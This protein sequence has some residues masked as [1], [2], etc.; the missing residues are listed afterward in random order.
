MTP[1]QNVSVHIASLQR[2]SRSGSLFGCVSRRSAVGGVAT[3]VLVV[4]AHSR[5]FVA[6]VALPGIAL[7]LSYL[8]TVSAAHAHRAQLRRLARVLDAAASGDLT[9]AMP[10]VSG[11]DALELAAP[12]SAVLEMLREAIVVMS[13]GSAALLTGTRELHGLSNTMSS[14]AETTAA[15]ATAVAVAADQVSG[16]AQR[17][18]AATEEF[19]ATIRDVAVHAGEASAV[20]HGATEQAK[21][22]NATVHDLGAASGKVTQVVELISTIARQTH[23]LAL[24]ATLEAARA[25]EAGRGFAVV[26]GEVKQLA[27]QTAAATGSVSDTVRSMQEGAAEV[28]GAIGDITVTIGRVSESQGAIAA[29]VEEQTAT[30]NEMGRSA[31]EAANGA[32]SIADNIAAL[33]GTARATA[34]AG[35]QSRTTAAEFANLAG[36]FT[37]ITERYRI[38]DRATRAESNVRNLVTEAVTNGSV[39]RIEDTV[40][41]EGLH[42]FSFR[43]EWR[44]STGNIESDGTNSYSCND[45]DVAVL[46]FRGTRASFFGVTDANHGIVGVSVDDGPEQF[47]DEYSASRAA[48]VK[49]WTSPV[50]S[51]GEHVLTIRVTGR[52]NPASR[53]TWAAVD[54]VDVS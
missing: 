20:A 12:A 49:L 43:G 35:A 9:V 32:A 39:T 11:K 27:E 30:T 53:Y 19:N 28:A 16:S 14:A 50:L 3:L 47:V 34:Y 17:V 4:V 36:S 24:N 1:S 48:G 18:A 2:R 26:A 46:R 45:G 5:G 54:R 8:L 37:A 44:H 7:T 33:A 10:T 42:Q 21:A 6:S 13:R 15:R 40:R 51:N 23:L 25:G 52:M 31:T 22:T 41:G 38:D 29:A